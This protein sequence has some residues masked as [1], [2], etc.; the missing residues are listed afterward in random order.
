MSDPEW[1]VL[2]AHLEQASSDE[3]HL[4]AWGWNWD[5]SLEPLQWIV[6]HPMCDR[7]TALLM[8]WYGGAGYH[9][10]YA[11]RDDV[12]THNLDMYDWLRE[13]EQRYVDGFY[14]R[15]ELAFDPARDDGHDWTREYRTLVVKRAIPPLMYQALNGRVIGP[16]YEDGYPP[17]VWAALN[18]EE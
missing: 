12:P 10:Q 2:R 5:N 8:Y 14:V 17:E 1:S 9:V 3:W 7:A 13:I 11:T 6:T 4:V 18:R 16:R 15:Q